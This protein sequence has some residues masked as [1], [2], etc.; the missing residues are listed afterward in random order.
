[1]I[2][3][4]LIRSATAIFSICLCFIEPVTIS[5]K[6]LRKVNERRKNRNWRSLLE[7]GLWYTSQKYQ[8]LA[9]FT[10]HKPG[11]ATLDENK[12]FNLR[13]WRDSWL[14]W[15]CWFQCPSKVAWSALSCPGDLLAWGRGG[16]QSYSGNPVSGQQFLQS[17]IAVGRSWLAAPAPNT[18]GFITAEAR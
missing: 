3:N 2:K 11:Q 6:M 13:L 17:D 14:Q 10:G 12:E 5:S 8:T 18:R 7:L 9:R 15:S 1:M 4:L 16:G